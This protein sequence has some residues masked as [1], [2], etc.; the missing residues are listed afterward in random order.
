LGGKKRKGGEKADGP[1]L[2]QNRDHERR[3]HLQGH[4]AALAVKAAF[5]G[6]AALGHWAL[7]A[8]SG[9]KGVFG[10]GAEKRF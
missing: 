4:E 8:S 3:G 5:A 9:R 1:K 10:R 2:G 6:W 7:V